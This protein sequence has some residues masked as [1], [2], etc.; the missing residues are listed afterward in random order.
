[1]QQGSRFPE[2]EFNFPDIDFKKIN[3]RMILTGLVVLAVIWL[4]TGIYFVGPQEAG[5]VRRFGQFV[6]QTEPGALDP[7]RALT[8]R[9]REV[10]QMVGTGSTSTEIGTALFISP[11]TVEAHRA[12][13]M[14]KLG[15][16]S[17]SELVR[18]CIRFGIM[19]SED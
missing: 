10:L 5:V 17:Q 14:R 11:R 7:Y 18:Y 12:K 15:L 9:E 8:E 2:G 16:T 3:P 1:M 13:I 4:L 19:P 6:R